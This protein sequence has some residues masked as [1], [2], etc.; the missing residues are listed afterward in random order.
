VLWVNVKSIV[1][2]TPYDRAN[3]ENWNRALAEA[4][5]AW[6][7]MRIYDWRNQVKDDW[8]TTD[9]IHFTSEGYA[10]RARMIAGALAEAFPPDWEPTNGGRPGDCLVEAP[11]QAL[12]DE[13]EVLAPLPG[14][15]LE[16]T[17]EQI[18]DAV[19]W[20]WSGRP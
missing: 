18:S 13:S 17:P 14:E 2:G 12:I 3:M 1:S 11:K 16:P 15:T 7:N 5:P 10:N 4:C 20:P 9:G 6:P 19:T 8:V